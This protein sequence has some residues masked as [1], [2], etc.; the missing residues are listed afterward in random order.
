MAK[1]LREGDR[2]SLVLQRMWTILGCITAVLVAIVGVVS[3]SEGNRYPG[4]AGQVIV[5]LVLIVLSPFFALVPLTIA[6]GL[7]RAEQI[8]DRLDRLD[9]ASR[10]PAS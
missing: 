7:R 10:S 4:S 3:V 8:L 5:G 9:A 2:L 6:M 1:K